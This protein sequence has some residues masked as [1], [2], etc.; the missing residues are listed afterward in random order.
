MKK[1]LI[2]YFTYIVLLLIFI[3]YSNHFLMNI[4]HDYSKLSFYLEIF[5]PI[6]L[7]ILL[8]IFIGIL[9]L[10][11][12][13]QKKGKW[14]INFIKIIFVT[15]PCLYCIINLLAFDFGIKILKFLECESLFFSL[16]LHHFA[17]DSINI[18]L[19]YS[20]ITSLYKR[21]CN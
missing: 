16:T 7:N 21:E 20:I 1:N 11:E 9:R 13:F 5:S 4:K 2:F 14:S 6:V 3:F 17:L 12:E 19:G 8:G 15:L 18:L 10:Y